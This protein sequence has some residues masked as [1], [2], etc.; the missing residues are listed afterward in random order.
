MCFSIACLLKAITQPTSYDLYST[1]P[2]CPP[3]TSHMWACEEK[4]K[5]LGRQAG[6]KACDVAI[7]K[8]AR[9]LL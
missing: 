3:H 1:P 4:A 8:L 5:Y 7:L 9:G 6:L 2:T